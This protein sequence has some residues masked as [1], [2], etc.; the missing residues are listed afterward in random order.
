MLGGQHVSNILDRFLISKAIMMDGL[1]WNATVIDTLGSDHWPIL[2]T[3][4][5]T[6]NPGRK[7]FYF[8][9]LWFGNFEIHLE[10]LNKIFLGS[11]VQNFCTHP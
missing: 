8:E 3:L 1:A 4:N 9:K 10:A 7:P 2:L 6:R 5:I 11:N